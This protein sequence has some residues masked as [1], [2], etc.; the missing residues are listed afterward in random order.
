ML[1]AGSPDQE[2]ARAPPLRGPDPHRAA[3]RPRPRRQGRPL[4]LPR[5]ALVHRPDRPLLAL[6]LDGLPVLPPEA[7]APPDRRTPR[8]RT[9]RWLGRTAPPGSTPPD[10]TPAPSSCAPAVLRSA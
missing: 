7:A 4:H 10:A 1:S 8:G 9:R 3:P 6:L 5:F 2:A